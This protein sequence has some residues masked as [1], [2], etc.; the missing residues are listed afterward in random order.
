MA[1]IQRGGA[2][3]MQSGK[4]HSKKV[5]QGF[6]R[7]V[8]PNPQ[9]IMTDEL[10]AYLGIMTTTPRTKGQPQAWEWVR[11]D[12]HTNTVEGVFSLFKRSIMGSFHQVS[13]K[14][15]DRYLDEFEWRFNNRRTRICS[16]TRSRAL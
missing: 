16:A 4:T 14:H 12:V 1:A 10:P 3:R 9:R 7:D 5:I 15:L 8:A 13:G 2:V 6:V 11:G